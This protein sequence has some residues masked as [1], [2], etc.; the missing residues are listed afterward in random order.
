MPG[1]GFYGVTTRTP[2]L[3]DRCVSRSQCSYTFTAWVKVTDWLC[4]KPECGD[5]GLC[6]QTEVFEGVD[7]MSSREVRTPRVLKHD[8][9]TKKPILYCPCHNCEQYRRWHAKSSRWK[10]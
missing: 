7:P 1:V 6:L 2:A 10:K 5:H 8:P 4:R 9:V 3:K